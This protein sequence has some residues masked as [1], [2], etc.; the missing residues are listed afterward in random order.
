MSALLKPYTWSK[1]PL[2]AAEPE[3]PNQ[4][5]TAFQKWGKMI[6]SAV[7]FSVEEKQRGHYSVWCSHLSSLGILSSFW[8]ILQSASWRYSSLQSSL[9][10]PGCKASMCWS[11]EGN[12]SLQRP[13]ASFPVPC[14]C[15]ACPQT[16]VGD[17][18]PT[19][20]DKIKTERNFLSHQVLSPAVEGNHII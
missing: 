13:V 17:I 12:C 5:Q 20:E 9:C 18:W 2:I 4:R 10:T 11:L 15:R 6:L 14:L 1:Y 16:A 3:F 19:Q 8:N 7:L